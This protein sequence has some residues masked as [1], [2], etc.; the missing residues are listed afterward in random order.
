LL[1]PQPTWIGGKMNKAH[2]IISIVLV[3]ITQV[4]ALTVLFL[5]STIL[6]LGYSF[7][8]ILSSLAIVYFYCTKCPIRLSGCMHVVI[9]PVTQ[10]FPERKQESYSKLD[11]S[12]VIIA[13]GVMILLPQVWLWRFPEAAAAFWI[14]LA[15][16][17]IQINRFICNRCDNTLCIACRKKQLAN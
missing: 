5:E 15:A 3:F 6:G 4:I 9:G 2:G 10:V 11:Y 8:F 13:L 16:A 12:V 7:L 14:A 17:G 1:L